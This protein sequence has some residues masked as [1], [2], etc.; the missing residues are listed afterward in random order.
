MAPNIH[1]HRNNYEENSHKDCCHGKHRHTAESGHHHHHHH[2]GHGEESEGGLRRSLFLT[3]IAIVLLAGAMWLDEHASLPDWQMLLIYLVPYLMVG[4]GTLREAAE[5]ILHGRI[6]NEDFLMT[7]ATLGA[8]GIGFLPGAETEF[9]EAVFVMLF[10]QV[11]ELFEHYAEGQSRQSISHLMDIRP[12]MARVERGGTTV[13]VTPQE[14]NVGE[15]IQVKPGEKIPLDGIV[16]EGSSSLDTAALTGESLP[17]DTGIGD[18]VSSGCINLN[19]LLRIK[20]TH[21]FDESTVSKIISLVESADRNKSHSEAFISRFA[22]VYTPIVVLSALTLAVIPPLV[23]GAPFMETF[24]TWLYRALVFLVVSCP[25][26]LVIS[27]PLTFFGG[28]G[29]ASRSGILIKGSRFFDTLAHVRSVVFDKTGTLTKG[30]FS[31]VAIHPDKISQEQLLHLAAHV[32]HFS[33]HPIAAAL[34]EAFPQEATDGC[35]TSQVSE[36]PG[37][38][39]KA[40]VEGQEVCV[41]NEKM[42]EEMGVEWHPCHHTGTIIHVAVDGLYAGH[43]V[44]SD[45]IKAGSADAIRQLG[46][47]G[48]RQTV[49][50][51][52]DRRE[53]AAEVAGK[54][55]ISEYHAELMPAGKV[56]YMEQLLRAMKKDEKLAFAGD[57]INDAPVLKRADVGIAMGAMGS[58]AAIEAADVVIMDDNP[59]KVATAIRLARRTIGIAHQNIIFAIGVKAGILL[60]AALGWG[61]MGLAVFGDVGVTVIAVL[62]ATRALRKY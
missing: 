50:L 61:S 32:E 59:E 5:G 22:R 29:G 40:M 51:T 43:V 23:A 49:M 41:G 25:C 20:A 13:E 54:L 2:H 58:E 12:E 57:G 37:K 6:F 47:L 7:I 52:G 26:A 9:A 56:E 55:G 19:G 60:L 4:S 10:F 39:I 28:I 42:M 8:L 45:S 48:V 33:T 14:V 46:E 30:K 62:N 18:S 34:R 11:G 44:I 1:T 38:G 16:L 35:H 21:T 53:V 36:M 24:P 17:R 31:V 15:T 27:I 3:G